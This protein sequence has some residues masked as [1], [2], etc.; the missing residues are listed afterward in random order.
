MKKM[1]WWVEGG[2]RDGLVGWW[3]EGGWRDGLVGW[4]VE[5][6]WSDG[7]MVGKMGIEVVDEWCLDW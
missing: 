2:W 3:V 1:G 6:G 7:L 5:G 4:W